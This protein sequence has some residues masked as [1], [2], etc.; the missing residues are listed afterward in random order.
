MQQPFFG[1]RGDGGTWSILGL[2]SALVDL[3]VFYTN[4]VNSIIIFMMMVE[5]PFSKING[6][7]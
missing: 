7:S 1:A 4:D 6:M 5:R 3:K 2:Q